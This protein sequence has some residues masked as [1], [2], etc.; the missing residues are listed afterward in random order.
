V[1]DYNS[2]SLTPIYASGSL[3]QLPYA[4]IRTITFLTYC[5]TT[6]PLLNQ[7]DN[8]PKR[9]ILTTGNGSYSHEGEEWCQQI[10]CLFDQ[11]CIP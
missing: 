6:H 2:C 3:S 4:V 7:F 8:G 11:V 10:V 5:S 9:G 1:Q